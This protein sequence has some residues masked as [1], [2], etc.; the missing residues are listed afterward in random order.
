[1]K[2]L[3]FGPKL[4][5]LALA[6]LLFT[7]LHDRLLHDVLYPYLHIHVEGVEPTATEQAIGFVLG[8]LNFVAGFAGMIVLAAGV[9]FSVFDLARRLVGRWL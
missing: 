9:F 3:G 5:L 8:L 1:M 4:I 6:M 2:K 7:L